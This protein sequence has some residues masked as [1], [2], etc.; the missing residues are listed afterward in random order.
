MA[1]NL[2]SLDCQANKE[3]TACQ[4]Y[5][6]RRVNQD[7][8][9]RVAFPVCQAVAGQRASEVPMATRVSTAFQ[10]QKE[11]LVLLEILVHLVA[12]CRQVT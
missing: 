5:R 1:V 8:L 10:V 12:C 6:A 3:K 7:R 9:E 11:Y 2:V 4:D